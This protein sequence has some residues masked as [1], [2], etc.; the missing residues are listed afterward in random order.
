MDDA[1]V[2]KP[3]FWLGTTRKDL[4]S[5]PEAVRETIGYGLYLAQK[6]GKHRDAKPLKGFHGAGV[7]EIVDDH[8][9]DT[10]RAVYTVKLAGAVYVLHAFPKKSK[11]GIATPKHVM[12][13]VKERLKQARQHYAELDP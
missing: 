4:R 9:G 2:F 5:F 13:L 1:D 8:D 7:L 6:G 10:Y 12:N 3:L 11:T